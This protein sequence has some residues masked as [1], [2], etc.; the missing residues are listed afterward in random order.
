[1]GGG[2]TVCGRCGGA[3]T[4]SA[5]NQPDGSK[6]VKLKCS[7]LN[8]GKDEL[9]HPTVEKVITVKGE[10]VTQRHDQGRVSVS[11]DILEE[12]VW[13]RV[14]DKLANRAQWSKSLASKQESKTNPRIAKVGEEIRDLEARRGRTQEAH[15]AGILSLDEAAAEVRRLDAAIR[16]AKERESRLLD[17]PNL[18][19]M[20]ITPGE[21]IN[22]RDM[23]P[24]QRRNLLRALIEKV[25]VNEW[26]SDLP[27]M[28]LSR[29]GETPEQ[30][31]ERVE[32]LKREGMGRRVDIVWR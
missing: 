1:M 30:Y 19:A 32:T 24:M 4:S 22:W 7:W 15:L 6:I 14:I 5:R 25:I 21:M 28:S 3:L 27:S 26:P 20:G 31:R 11:H 9:N 8:N 2:L 17:V 18:S 13:E 10:K 23:A 16:D 12:H 29:K